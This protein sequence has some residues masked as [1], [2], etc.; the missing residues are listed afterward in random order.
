MHGILY[1][2]QKYFRMKK[3]ISIPILGNKRKEQCSFMKKLMEQI[4]RFGVVGLFCFFIDYGL[5]V[6]LANFC[7][8]HYMI[9]KFIGFVL[10][11]VVN[12]IL[13][14]KFVF[15]QKKEM[16]KGKEFTIFIILSAIGL[17]LNEIILFVCIDVIHANSA[18][19]QS[20]LSEETMLSLS[21]LLATGIVM[22]Y[23]FISR[24]L[25]LERK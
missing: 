18:M 13:S 22:V 19:L 1:C 3:F 4:L 11:A 10:S 23:N 20:Y 15:T 14:I 7:G 16:N 24:K 5:T 2:M 25:F 12:Y 9:S 8:I 6:G 21:A 17:L